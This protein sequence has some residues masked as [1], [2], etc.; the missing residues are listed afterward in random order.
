MVLGRW[1]Q[2]ETMSLAWIPADRPSSLAKDADTGTHATSLGHGA[3]ARQPIGTLS[4]Q[5]TMVYFNRQY[6]PP[7]IRSRWLQIST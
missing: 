7:T 3:G 2:R 4:T 6:F 5:A 1:L